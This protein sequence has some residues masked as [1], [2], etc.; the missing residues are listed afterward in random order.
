[1]SILIQKANTSIKRKTFKL[2]TYLKVIK[3]QNF[4]KS[5]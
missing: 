3:T 2:I 1:M 5:Y 4:V